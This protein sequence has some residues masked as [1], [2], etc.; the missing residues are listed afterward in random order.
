MSD[1]DQRRHHHAADGRDRRQRR[2]PTRRQLAAQQLALDLQADQ[3]EEDRHQAVVDPQQQRLVERQR[4]DP[5]AE[6]RLQQA[7]R[8][9]ASGE[10]SISSARA[11]PP[12]ARAPRRLVLEE[13][14]HPAQP[15]TE[16]RTAGPH[17]GL[18]YDRASCV[19]FYR[20]SRL[21]LS[22]VRAHA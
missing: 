21:R 17:R 22:R 18:L 7:V 11:P 15:L 9:H 14:S 3:E 4:A 1:V 10:L 8:V 13:L 16:I 5:H 2:L 6:P 19:P 20:P 12:S